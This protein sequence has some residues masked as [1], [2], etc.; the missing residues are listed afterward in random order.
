MRHSPTPGRGGGALRMG[1]SPPSGVALEAPSASRAIPAH[2]N[3]FPADHMWGFS[4]VPCCC[5]SSMA[6]RGAGC[7]PAWWSARPDRADAILVNQIIAYSLST[8]AA[9]QL[10][11][12]GRC[13]GVERGDHR[14]LSDSAR[15][16]V[17]GAKASGPTLRAL[18]RA[19]R[20][21]RLSAPQSPPAARA[22]RARPPPDG[23]RLSTAA[24]VSLEEIRDDGVE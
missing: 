20:P 6:V 8:V 7:R 9:R 3:G 17:D 13:S 18:Q 21:R 16:L 5:R 23:Q 11:I 14:H 19:D 2:V 24:I 15:L 12:V 22:S 1:R 4:H 10:Q